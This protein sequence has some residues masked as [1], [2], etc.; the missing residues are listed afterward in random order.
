MIERLLLRGLR[1]HEEVAAHTRGGDDC[2][3]EQDER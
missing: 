3:D 2:E 1:F